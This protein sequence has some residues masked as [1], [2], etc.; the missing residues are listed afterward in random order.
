MFSVFL[1]LCVGTCL[2]LVCATSLSGSGPELHLVLENEVTALCEA[3]SGLNTLDTLEANVHHEMESLRESFEALPKNEFGNLPSPGVKYLLH[4]HFLRQYGWQMRGLE[5][6][7]D[8]W[9]GTSVVHA[10]GQTLSKETVLLLRKQLN[11]AGLGLHELALLAMSFMNVVHRQIELHLTAVFEAFGFQM[12]QIL[13]AETLDNIVN[14]FMASYV[15]GKD[16]QEENVNDVVEEA[17]KSYP[18]WDEHRNFARKIRKEMGSEDVA[19][20]FQQLLHEIFIVVQRHGKFQNAECVDLK[21]E[22]FS[23]GSAKGVSVGRV[24][25]SDFYRAALFKEKFQFSE[26][27]AYLRQLG[28]LDEWAE[29]PSIL[30]ANWINSF[31]NCV[32]T[33]AKHSVCCMDMCEPILS[34]IE[35]ELRGPTASPQTVLAALTPLVTNRLSPH[36]VSRLA[37]ISDYHAGEVHLHGR[38]FA[39]WLHHVF[40]QEC[41]YPHLSGTFHPLRHA[42]FESQTGRDSLATPEEMLQ[43]VESA[44]REPRQ[45]ETIHWEIEEEL[46]VPQTV[47]PVQQ[48]AD[49]VLFRVAG[50]VAAA[51]C[52][53]VAL[54][55]ASV[56]KKRKVYTV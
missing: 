55:P 32:G 33:S 1:A 17:E 9:N 15:L 13:A 31:S 51:V 6:D 48:G 21:Q 46:F 24:K 36:L 11:G 27:A 28:A 45:A 38:L 16:P 52:A 8:K 10:L 26:S 47:G 30:A 39:Q 3:F 7:G 14:V 43:F 44:Q 42:D 37:E 53:L 35:A 25:L 5:P 40:P 23:L 49:V 20:S 34:H 41:P 2:C 29:E 19:L 12:D 22:L 54:V 4:R 18:S 50:L 56:P